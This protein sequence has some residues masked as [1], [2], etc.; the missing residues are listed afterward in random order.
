M[1]N[2]THVFIILFLFIYM[3]STMKNLVL[4]LVLCSSCKVYTVKE[5]YNI[6]VYYDTVYTY[7]VIDK[8]SCVK[9]YESRI[10]LNKLEKI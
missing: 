9:Y 1:N 7:K 4:L 5:Q 2:N 6:Q 8:D 3:L 10:K